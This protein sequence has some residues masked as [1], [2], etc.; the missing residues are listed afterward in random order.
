MNIKQSQTT[1]SIKQIIDLHKACEI[2][3]DTHSFELSLLFKLIQQSSTPIFE[4]FQKFQ[5]NSF[6]KYADETG[7]SILVSNEKKYLEEVDKMIDLQVEISI[8]N[9]NIE[10]I[11]KNP[12]L[13]MNPNIIASFAPIISH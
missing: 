11:E 8:P 6:E 13:F 4:L 5:K 1:L 12:S 7:A 10:V 2:I 3:G 9:I